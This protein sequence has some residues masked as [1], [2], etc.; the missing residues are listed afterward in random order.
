MHGHGVGPGRTRTRRWSPRG[1]DPATGGHGLRTA[2]PSVNEHIP[3]ED[4]SVMPRRPSREMLSKE[5]MTGRVGSA[6]IATRLAITGMLAIT[7]VT[8]ACQATAPSSSSVI[9][10]ASPTPPRSS[11]GPTAAAASSRPSP[12]P[13]LGASICTD[14][15]GSGAV[16]PSTGTLIGHVDQGRILIGIEGGGGAPSGT[17]AYAVIDRAGLHPVP[18]TD[19]TLAH[20]VWAAD[21]GIIFDSE[22]NDDRHLFRMAADGSNVTQLTSDRRGAEQ[23]A[24]IG[25]GGR[26]VFTH[27]S[28]S[29]PR[30]L[31]LHTAAADGSGMTDLT[32]EQQLGSPIGDDQPTVSPD[33]KT[34]VFVR[35]IDD[36]Q[37]TGALFSVPFGGGTAARLTDNAGGVSYPRFSPD[38]KWILFTQIDGHGDP[39]LWLEPATGGHP[40]QL[41]T[42]P[43]GTSA[44]NGDWSPDGKEI[45][46][47]YW[48]GWSYNELHL[49]GADGHGERVLWRGGASTAETADWVAN[50]EQDQGGSVALR[51][52]FRHG[53]PPNVVTSRRREYE[54]H[55]PE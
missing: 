21:G 32:P 10:L 44:F 55:P 13:T 26:L 34:V 30:D 53:S 17:F 29:E 46:M 54:S 49:I 40:R 16:V 8:A 36:A 5:A 18:T 15:R 9:P 47:E 35:F 3:P 4:E 28:C 33:G 45:T 27:Y 20:P 7:G 2:T 19:W 42:F 22:R 24:A 38:G 14:T 37:T 50:D 41:T 23:S 12:S 1:V 31:G 6:G 39:A 43:A 48:S 11:S 25:T 52:R 51:R